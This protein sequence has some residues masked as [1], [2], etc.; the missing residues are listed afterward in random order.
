MTWVLGRIKTTPW[1]SLVPDSKG[2]ACSVGDPGLSLAQED[3][4]EKEWPPTPVFLPGNS[5]DRGAWRAAVLGLANSWT[6]LSD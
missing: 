2:S 3:P 4:L 6:R 1:A 5:R